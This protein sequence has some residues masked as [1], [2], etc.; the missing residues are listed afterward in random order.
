MLP[1]ASDTVQ[2]P[3]PEQAPVQPAKLLP[4]TEA[5]LSTTV[6]WNRAEQVADGHWINW[7]ESL[8]APEPDTVTLRVLVGS[9]PQISVV[10]T[11]GQVA[12]G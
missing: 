6:P 12:A 8:T 2:V 11:P 10:S 9:T 7:V 1:P 3:V 5:A 4:A